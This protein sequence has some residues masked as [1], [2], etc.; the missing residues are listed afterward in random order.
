MRPLVIYVIVSAT[1]LSIVLLLTAQILPQVSG[2]NIRPFD[3][4]WPSS[5]P[6]AP[7][8]Q[9][10]RP[11]DPICPNSSKDEAWTF[12]PRLHATNHALTEAQCSSAFPLL[13]KEIDR[14]VEYRHKHGNITTDDLD[15][16]WRNGGIVRILVR[17]N[18]VSIVDTLDVERGHRFRYLATLNS[19]QTAVAGSQEPLPNIEFTYTV[20]DFPLGHS[21]K[22][23][24]TTLGYSRAPE[25][26]SLWLMPDFGFWGWP[27]VGMNSYID[28]RATILAGE[29]D[30]MEKDPKLL[31]RGG[32]G[33]GHDIRESLLRES[34]GQ[35]WNDVRGI[36]WS[37]Q[38]DVDENLITM[39]EHCRSMFVAMT[40]GFTWSGRLKFLL[41]CH[42]V[43][44]S[45]EL[46]YL[47][48]YHHL[49]E[50]SGEGQNY[51]KLERDFS[52]LRE[53]MEHL[54]HPDNLETEARRIA[55][56]AR[57]TFRERYLTPAAI[58]C[59]WR[60]LIR[61]WASVQGFEPAVWQEF[62]GEVVGTGL[63]RVPRGVPFESYVIME[64][65]EW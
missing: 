34:E 4:S 54:L 25:Q 17:D 33:Q 32:L 23:H 14:A 19:L 11:V 30:F 12:D 65:L 15:M 31:W 64:A 22:N 52:D 48:F 26:E 16:S 41:N 57:A 18:H 28:H 2:S 59:Y 44:V 21:G 3:L 45:H 50:D 13:Y 49:L 6:P 39:A 53:T 43:L 7:P 20:T 29:E 62:E 37:N 60:A 8:A 61:G 42:S 35:I 9:V 63:K 38:T 40:E 51:V 55:D 56:N 36:E 5:S 47:E 10:P 24:H 46:K 1:I 58:S 27:K